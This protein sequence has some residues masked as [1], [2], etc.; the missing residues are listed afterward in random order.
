MSCR[1]VS[2]CLVYLFAPLFAF[3]QHTD[4]SVSPST[5][6]L[7]QVPE[8]LYSQVPELPKSQG[9]LVEGIE[10][11]S[12]A[13]RGGLRKHDIVVKFDNAPI[14]NAKAMLEK[15]AQMKPG[16]IAELTLFRAGQAKILPFTLPKADET[17]LN[18]YT[19]PKGFLKGGSP[20]PVSIQA[21]P[22]D[23]GQFTVTIL[24]YAENSGKL[25]RLNLH[26]LLP[27]IETQFQAQARD[28]MLSEPIVDMVD[29]ALRRLRTIS[30][31]QDR[32]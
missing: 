24:Y 11:D 31:D 25:E 8:V 19:P 16:E 27:E 4:K 1:F 30:K 14:E 13:F 29:V 22:M 17:G 9:A 21:Q 26:G 32:K 28:R 7:G 2:V 23:K 5:L 6:K 3:A 10:E 20:P 15:L 18:A 12:P